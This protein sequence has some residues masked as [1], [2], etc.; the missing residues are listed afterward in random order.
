MC[1]IQSIPSQHSHLS[2]SLTLLSSSIGEESVWDLSKHLFL[3][4]CSFW[5]D[6]VY[7]RFLLIDTAIL[8][9]QKLRQ[10]FLSC[11]FEK[12][13]A[14]ETHNSHPVTVYWHRANQSFHYTQTPG[15]ELKVSNIFDI[16]L[17]RPGFKH[18]PTAHKRTLYQLS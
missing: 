5:F 14:T 11:H 13:D 9:T 15:G 16:G 17:S 18:W 3:F 1:L 6:F 10:L 8:E 2:V 4:E 12:C 7:L